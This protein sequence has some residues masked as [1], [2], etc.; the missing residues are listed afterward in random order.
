MRPQRQL[1]VILIKESICMFRSLHISRSS[2]LEANDRFFLYSLARSKL[3]RKMELS[4]NVHQDT[5]ILNQLDDVCVR[6]VFQ[7]LHLHDL[8]NAADVCKRFRTIAGEI[9]KSVY[10]DQNTLDMSQMIEGNKEFHKQWFMVRWLAEKFMVCAERLFRNF[11]HLIKALHLTGTG[12]MGGM[13]ENRL[14]ML[15]NKHCR[16]SLLE[17]RL[18]DF[19]RSDDFSTVELIPLFR[20]LHKLSVYVDN[21]CESF[22]AC[23]GD[24][25][26]LTHLEM[27]DV[28]AIVWIKTKFPKLETL[29]ISNNSEFDNTEF[30][31]FLELHENL[32]TLKYDDRYILS[33]FFSILSTASPKLESFCCNFF[34]ILDYDDDAE[35]VEK[36]IL[37]L[38]K[39]RSLRKLTFTCE[40][41]TLDQLVVAFEEEHTPIEYV[42]LV[43]CEIESDVIVIVYRKSN[44]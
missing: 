14:L 30:E 6:R 15:V 20:G 33:D 12:E 1:N 8:C 9:F 37:H 13:D 39:L 22:V 42:N 16:A 27:A 7:C 18:V 21:L 11:G 10:A 3:I 40:A 17:L 2:H 38:S 31:V 44:R 24:C 35:E 19:G 32:R 5:Q 26:N 43:E 23:L 28:P 41:S 4:S 34:E 36:N 29:I 25:Q